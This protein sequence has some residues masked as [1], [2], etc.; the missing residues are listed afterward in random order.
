[1]EHNWYSQ[2]KRNGVY[3]TKWYVYYIQ[4]RLNKYR[5]DNV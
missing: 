2:V 1:M 5:D 4:G 3:A